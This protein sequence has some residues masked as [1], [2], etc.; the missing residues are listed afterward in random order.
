MQKDAK[1]VIDHFHSH[2]VEQSILSARDKVQLNLDLD[3]Y[4]IK[5]YFTHISGLDN[6]Y[7]S[8]KLENAKLLLDKI[9]AKP[10]E[11]L[12]IGDTT[13]DFEIAKKLRLNRIIL[14]I[15]HQSTKK[16]KKLDAIIDNNL[17]EVAHPKVSI[18]TK[19]FF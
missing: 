7:A 5:R 17:Y 19:E 1:H 18:N 6:H 13:H 3:H 16:L 8:G 9:D 11:I 2:G 4:D 10:S 14:D 15:G 12:M